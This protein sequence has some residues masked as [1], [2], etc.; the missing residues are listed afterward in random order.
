MAPKKQMILFFLNYMIPH[1]IKYSQKVTNIKKN[2][3][4]EMMTPISLII[5]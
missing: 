5:K 4:K 2:E 1:S 3:K